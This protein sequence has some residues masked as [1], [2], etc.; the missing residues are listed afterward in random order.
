MKMNFLILACLCVGLWACGTV[1]ESPQAE[2]PTAT[3]AQ[4]TQQENNEEN[5]TEEESTDDLEDDC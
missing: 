3:T 1:T 2:Q 5:E 4:E